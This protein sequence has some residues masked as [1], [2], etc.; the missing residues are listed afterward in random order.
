MAENSTIYLYGEIGLDV[1]AQFV[2][3]ALDDAA[4]GVD[5]RINSGGGEVFE[6]Q[7]IYTLLHQ[8][9]QNTGQTVRVFVDSLAA[10]IA[11]VIAMA[12]DEVLIA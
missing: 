9:K 2:R 11:S 1:D 5:V 8:H 6:G 4:D 12:G 7:A 3:A 10:S